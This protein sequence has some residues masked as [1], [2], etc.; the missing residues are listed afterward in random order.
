M[1][2][3]KETGDNWYARKQSHANRQGYSMPDTLRVGSSGDDV[4]SCQFLLTEKEF[5]TAID[6]VF[7]SGTELQVRAF[8]SS[9]GLVADGI[10]GPETW[11][12]LESVSDVPIRMAHVASFFP[13][14]LPQVYKLSGGQCP[15]N[16]P[17]VSLK[18]IGN[19]TTNC[20]LFTSWLLSMSFPVVFTGDQWSL[21]MVSSSDDSQVPIV[22]NWGP[23]VAIQ[24]GISRMEPGTGPW[25]VQ[26]FTNTGGHS[27]I[28]LDE[29]QATGKI[30]TLEAN[31]SIDGAG[32]NQIGPLRDVINPGL[33]WPDKVTQTWSNRIYSKRSVHIV[34]L[35][36]TG[37][38][39]WL[40]GT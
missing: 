31:D 6:G 9:V 37:V 36:I 12:Q 5:P 32:W 10:V 24:W 3:K 26:W 21:W 4:I 30:L 1:R 16:P 8:Q 7:G 22:P 33:D 25:L 13:D 11:V 15:S 14:M 19:E 38:R 18:R 17:G 29:D 23:R 34:S 40:G 39:E 2:K 20:V 28:V 27:L 35:N